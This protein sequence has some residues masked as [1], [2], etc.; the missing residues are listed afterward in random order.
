MSE[1]IHHKRLN[2]IVCM[3]YSD[4]SELYIVLITDNVS[5]QR[6]G[7]SRIWD[8]TTHI[9]VCISLGCNDT[10][11]TGGHLLSLRACQGGA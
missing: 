8:T 9:C 11:L 5:I 3:R 2:I 1:A 10:L 6:W 7:I 4:H